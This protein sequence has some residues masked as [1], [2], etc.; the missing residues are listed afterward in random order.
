MVPVAIELMNTS[1]I[2]AIFVVADTKPVGIVH[3]HD[4]LR[5]GAA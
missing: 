2:T 5:V 1:G 4:F 3:M